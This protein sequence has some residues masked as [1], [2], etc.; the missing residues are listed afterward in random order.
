MEQLY[1]TQRFLQHK[2][3]KG[4]L[5][6]EII[7]CGLVDLRAKK[8]CHGFWITRDRLTDFHHFVE[9]RRARMRRLTTANRVQ[10]VKMAMP[11][12][13]GSARHPQRLC[14]I[15]SDDNE[16]AQP[17]FEDRLLA[18]Q[19]PP[20]LPITIVIAAC[21]FRRVET[22]HVQVLARCAIGGFDRMHAVPHR[23]MRLLERLELHW[24]LFTVEK[25]SF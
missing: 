22:H 1:R 9:F 13:I 6:D 14:A 23:W 24:N 25:G 10:I 8:I 15:F 20:N 5:P 3:A 11:D 21:V 7:S 19:S 4:K 16:A 18:V 2:I 12:G 17:E